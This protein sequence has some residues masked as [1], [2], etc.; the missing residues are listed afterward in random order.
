ML[1]RV[2]ELKDR[3]TAEHSQRVA[4]Y[5]T[6]LAGF[7]NLSAKEVNYIYWGSLLH[8]IGKIVIPEAILFKSG[9]LD[10]IEYEQIKQH[11]I[12]GCEIVR[13]EGESQDY[14]S[15]IKYH[16]ERLDGKGY[17]DGLVGSQIPLIARL[18]TVVDAF[19]AMMSH[20]VYRQSI[21]LEKT[22]EELIAGRCTQFD[23]DC[24]DVFIDKVV[25][26]LFTDAYKNLSN[27]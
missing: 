22:L 23:P 10:S 2:L 18:V 17:P 20:R 16:H 7:F 19:D 5:A 26:K 4:K 14:L 6:V 21:G 12:L 8:D 11:T 24:V 15:I 25:P 13:Q 27:I 3:Y 1:F 9:R